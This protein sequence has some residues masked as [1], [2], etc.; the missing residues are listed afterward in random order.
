MIQ[1]QVSLVMEKKSAWSAWSAFPEVTNAF[2]EL[3]SKPSSISSQTM[4]QIERFVILMYS[5]TCSLTRVDEARKEFFAQGRTIENIPPTKAALVQH[6]KRATYQAGYVWSQALV[7]L[8]HLPDPE[9]WGWI[10]H[11]NSGW[12]PFWTELPEAS[13]SCYE[14]IHCGCK[15]GCNQTCKCRSSSLLCTELCNCKGGCFDA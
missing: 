13:A 2:L 1:L 4:D 10:F 12:R 3:S 11:Q 6:T 9:S 8:P 7:P 14:L 15:K 5:R